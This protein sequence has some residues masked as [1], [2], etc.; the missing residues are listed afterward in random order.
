MHN[1]AAVNTDVPCLCVPVSHPL[2][3]AAPA[4]TPGS[5]RQKWP[6]QRHLLFLLLGE[7]ALLHTSVMRAVGLCT[8][9]FSQVEDV[10]FCPS[11][12]VST[13]GLS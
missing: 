2:Q 13:L 7:K 12:G 9:G 8:R 5:A 1:T 4:R 3:G 11:L 6:S 10:S